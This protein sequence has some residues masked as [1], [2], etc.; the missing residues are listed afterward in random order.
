MQVFLSEHHHQYNIVSFASSTNESRYLKEASVKNML[1]TIRKLYF[2]NAL[3]LLHVYPYKLLCM[4][5][6]KRTYIS[7]RKYH[8]C[9]RTYQAKKLKDLKEPGRQ[10]Q[11]FLLESSTKCNKTY[12]VLSLLFMMMMMVSYRCIYY[13]LLL[14]NAV[15][16]IWMMMIIVC[17]L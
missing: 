2:C 16:V 7:L 17:S 10:V 15:L 9:S 8:F 11:S 5:M 6:C 4:M 14:F 1:V 12:F 3:L 13:V